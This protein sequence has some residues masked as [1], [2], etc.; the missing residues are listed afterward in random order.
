MAEE[1]E[2]L[3]SGALE[4]ASDRAEDH[5]I[6]LGRQLCVLGQGGRAGAGPSKWA[7]SVGASATAVEVARIW[8]HDRRP[9]HHVARLDRQDRHLAALRD[10]HPQPDTTIE[11][12]GHEVRGVALA[13]EDCVRVDARQA[14][15]LGEP[16]AR[17]RAQCVRQ[18]RRGEILVE[19]RA[20]A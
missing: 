7:S 5:R 14:A 6:E 18:P 3:E 1:I 11:D 16:Y 9:T 20:G 4:S 15:Q 13:E 8:R 2:K 10:T 17:G 12:D 19:P